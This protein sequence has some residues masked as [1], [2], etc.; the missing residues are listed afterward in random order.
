MSRGIA[1]LSLLLV[2]QCVITFAMLQPRQPTDDTAR[3]H[4]LLEADPGRIDEIRVSD[5]FDNAVLLQRVGEQWLLPELDGLPAAAERVEALLGA[6]HNSGLWPVADTSVARQRFQVAEY[7]YQRRVELFAD[8]DLVGSVYLGT[9][10]GFRRVHARN[11]ARSAIFSIPFNNH[12][13]PVTG[14]EWLDNDLLRVRSP[15]AIVGEGYSLS[16]SDGQ[17][18]AGTG[19]TPDARELEALLDALRN[20]RIAGMAGRE[21]QRELAEAEADWVLSVTG[22]AG[23]ATLSLFNRDGRHY[24]HSSAYPYIFT[25]SAYTYNRLID[26]DLS[27]ISGGV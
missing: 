21:E 11:A 14:G 25:L 15:I 1:I 8:K 12:E 7:L 17:W 20:L 24:I 5:Q 3:P 16:F 10:P 9:S 26:T 19:A 27:L 2:V 13:A 4:R 22:L 6:L 18:V 23:D